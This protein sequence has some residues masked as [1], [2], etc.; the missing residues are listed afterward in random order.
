MDDSHIID[1]LGGTGTVA[2]ICEVTDGA[3]SQW[4]VNG[5]PKPRRMYLQLLRPEVF[6]PIDISPPDVDSAA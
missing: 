4:R 6:N 3:V 1:R 2:V 5:I